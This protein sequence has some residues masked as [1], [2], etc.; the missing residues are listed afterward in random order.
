MCWVR[1][2]AENSIVCVWWCVWGLGWGACD[3]QDMAKLTNTRKHEKE[4][5][6]KDKAGKE[7]EEAR[8]KEASEDAAARERIA[9]AKQTLSFTVNWGSAGHPSVTVAPDISGV[10]AILAKDVGEYSAPLLLKTHGLTFDKMTN[11]LKDWTV[12]SS[13][14][15]STKSVDRTSCA[16]KPAMGLSE[17]DPIWKA[18]LPPKTELDD[19]LPSTKAAISNVTLFA[20]TSEYASCDWEHQYLGSLRYHHEGHCAYMLFR[21]DHLDKG[22]KTLLNLKE[23]PTV[24]AMRVWADK[25]DHDS[26]GESQLKALIAAGLEVFHVKTQ[27][28]ETLMVPP[29]YLI[30]CTVLNQKLAT[31]VR[32]LFLPNGQATANAFTVLSKACRDSPSALQF[33]NSSLDM[34]TVAIKRRSN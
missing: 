26:L 5:A 29:G 31:G 18:F 13:K 28:G 11:T 30:A 10:A 32:R 14:H 20:Y 4:K 8:V 22:L 25:L 1:W 33:V 2:K 34:M 24:D 17:F 6:E 7:A 27:P 19:C 23:T 9:H 3:S 12:S 15:C 21:A 16:M